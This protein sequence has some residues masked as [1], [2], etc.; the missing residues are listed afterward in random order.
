M[1]TAWRYYNSTQ[2][3]AYVESADESTGLN[4]G[5]RII[6]IDETEIGSASDISNYINTKSVGDTVNVIVMRRGKTVTVSITLKEK[7]P[8]TSSTQTN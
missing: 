1:Y 8:D 4:R 7:V 2:S 3:G 5:D 6:S